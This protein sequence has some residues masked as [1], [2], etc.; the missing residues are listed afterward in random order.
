MASLGHLFYHKHEIS[1]EPLPETQID[2]GQSS[3]VPD[4]MLYDNENFRTPIIIEICHPNG[5]NNDLKKI[6]KL[7]DDN[8]FGIEE[9]FIYDYERNKWIKYQKNLG[10]ILLNPSYSNVLDLDLNK[11]L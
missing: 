10:Q 9:G 8:D 7:I 4:I 5:I 1:L 11:F 3:P 6:I 2:E